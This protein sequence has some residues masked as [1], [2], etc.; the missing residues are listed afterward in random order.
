MARF[1]SQRHRRIE[2]NYD[3]NDGLPGVVYILTNAAHKDSI[4][5]IGQSTISGHR[6]AQHMN[7]T[8]GT[9]TP[10]LF[11]C[12][13]ECPTDDCGRA[14]KAVH[15]R[16][17]AHRLTRQ[18]YF[19]VD[20]AIAKQVIIEECARHKGPSRPPV[21]PKEVVTI[22]AP[23]PQIRQQ[24]IEQ[25]T[26][27]ATNSPSRLRLFVIEPGLF[28]FGVAWY[29][30]WSAIPIFFVSL[31]INTMFGQKV[32]WL[33]SYYTFGFFGI[34]WYLYSLK[35]RRQD[36]LTSQRLLQAELQPPLPKVGSLQQVVAQPQ[37]PVTPLPTKSSAEP[38]AT[39]VSR[40]APQLAMPIKIHYR[41]VTTPLKPEPPAAAL[42]TLEQQA[43][44][45]LDNRSRLQE[46]LFPGGPSP[47]NKA[48]SILVSRQPEPLRSEIERLLALKS[49]PPQHLAAQAS[50]ATKL[51]A[52]EWV[53]AN[54]EVAAW[55]TQLAG[56]LG[57]EI[58]RTAKDYIPATMTEPL[59]SAVLLQLD[60]AEW[61][62]GRERVIAGRERL[63]EECGILTSEKPEYFVVDYAPEHLQA[64]IQR[65]IDLKDETDALR[66]EGV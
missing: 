55:L 47:S 59:R 9:E 11:V 25:S 63:R 42:Q 22:A 51:Q 37:G 26:W 29:G 66:S 7:Q 24:P 49:E 64:E 16:L 13:F 48:D 41:I 60:A 1:R 36:E 43:Q 4:L 2:P 39:S 20:I 6:R 44:E 21:A 10:K 61:V 14:E 34:V 50:D 28:V 5:K 57:G 56:R 17:A 38:Q 32:D 45:W 31:A 3:R 18:E 15:E 53:A 46:P 54:D 27:K 62:A 8:V 30:L 23:P 33:L 40:S 65:Q 58:V 52:R 19:E 12:V 35:Q